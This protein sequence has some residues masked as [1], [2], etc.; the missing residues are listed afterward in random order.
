MFTNKLQTTFTKIKERVERLTREIERQID[1]SIDQNAH[2]IVDYDEDQD[3]RECLTHL[4]WNVDGEGKLEL[5][6]A[7]LNLSR[8]RRNFLE[9]PPETS[10]FP[11]DMKSYVPM[12][13]VSLI[14]GDHFG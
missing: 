3:L 2:G 7:I 10:D 5:R 12:A 9:E 6:E 11:F 14:M 4:P 8:D 13:K 1:E